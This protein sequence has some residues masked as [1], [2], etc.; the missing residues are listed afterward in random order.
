MATE[1]LQLAPWSSGGPQKNHHIGRHGHLAA[2]QLT[3]KRLK[4]IAADCTSAAALLESGET[5]AATAQAA[6][7]ARMGALEAE[8]Q[9]VHAEARARDAA[10]QAR[11]GVLQAELSS[12][13]A[14][15]RQA[16][17]KLR[18]MMAADL[19]AQPKPEKEAMIP[20][21]LKRL[22][23]QQQIISEQDSRIRSGRST[24]LKK[25][26]KRRVSE[27]VE[28]ASAEG[29]P[30]KQPV[31]TATDAP[32]EEV[33]RDLA[34]AMQ[35]VPIQDAGAALQIAEIGAAG[36]AQ[37]AS[38]SCNP[39]QSALADLAPEQIVPAPTEADANAGNVAAVG[40][41]LEPHLLFSD[42]GI[43]RR[44]LPWQ[45]STP[46]P[47]APPPVPPVPAHF[48]SRA[49]RAAGADAAAAAALPPPGAPCRCVVRGKDARLGL[50]AFDCEQCRA[51]Y[52]AVG[53][54]GP[55]A[56]A[57]AGAAAYRK[58]A[59]RHRFAHAPVST[60]PGFWDLSFPPDQGAEPPG[61][62]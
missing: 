31:P 49:I 44:N 18:S 60:P 56:G 53:V 45:K 10:A 57:A 17:K 50:Q 26:K 24:P 59:S 25:S 54:A 23:A 52:S 8:L 15:R 30:R 33:A 47:S 22:Q 46:S 5:A 12:E 16:E 29:A 4:E 1:S 34:S 32:K 38:V 61:L 14:R 48:P 39:P 35:V 20:E 55:S 40:E 43:E 41:G 62:V 3:A 19:S 37:A 2:T 27:V 7:Q 58:V 9:A 28:V 6:T 13:R 42:A 51:F 21:L 11:L 36:P